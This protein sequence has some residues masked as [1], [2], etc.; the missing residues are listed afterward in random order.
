VTVFACLVDEIVDFWLAFVLRF[1]V[2]V[3]S[4]IS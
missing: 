1:F 2:Y 3:L 4:R